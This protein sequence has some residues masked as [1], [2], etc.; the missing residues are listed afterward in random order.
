MQKNRKKPGKAGTVIV[1]ILLIILLVGNIAGG[2][3]YNVIT[4][5]F[6][7]RKQMRK[8]LKKLRRQRG[9]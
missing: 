7:N 5:F 1:S 3:Y 2:M 6:P 9:M 4:Q 8:Q